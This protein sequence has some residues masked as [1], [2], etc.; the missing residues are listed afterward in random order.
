MDLPFSIQP[1]L[2][3]D[4]AALYPLRREDF[5]ALYA[6]ASD[7]AVWAQ[8]PNPDRWQRPVFEVFFEGAMQSA[9]AFRIVDKSSGDLAGSTRI[10][11][12]DPL[13]DSIMIG[14]TFFATRYWG[15][16]F[17]PATKAL[18][19]DYLFQ[20]VSKIRFHIGA[21]NLRSQIAITRL[22]AEKVAELEVAYF[23]EAPKTNFEYCLTRDHW[24]GRHTFKP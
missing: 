9:G 23:G 20:Y 19:F 1:I 10:Y 8:H 15:K 4:R 12:Y 17:N 6:A 16:G 3:D 18:L 21:S 11:G 14:Y 13:E 22:G 5:E 24:V 7:P 2:E